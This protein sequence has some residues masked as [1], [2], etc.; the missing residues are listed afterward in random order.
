MGDNLKYHGRYSVSWED[1]M[2][3]VG[4][5]MSTMEGVQYR[6]DVL[7]TMGILSSI[8]DIMIHVGDI[9]STVGVFGTLRYSDNKRFIPPQADKDN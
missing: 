5:S 1:I 6:G 3:N 9:M 8:G 7:S 2:M 4:D